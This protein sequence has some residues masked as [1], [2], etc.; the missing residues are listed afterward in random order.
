VLTRLAERIPDELRATL[1]PTVAALADADV[2][3]LVL[4]F[5]DS[6]AIRDDAAA[7]AC[8]LGALPPPRVEE[9]VASLLQGDHADRLNALELAEMV[10]LAGDDL[11][12]ALT[13]DPEPS[14]RAAAA[15]LLAARHARGEAGTL[16]IRMMHEASRDPGIMVPQA[17][18]HALRESTDSDAEEIRSRLRRHGSLRVRLAADANT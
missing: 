18:G 15:E 14:V 12:G 8:A 11:L 9:R 3:S 6:R 2:D 10:G 7:L 13:S 5:P 4:I 1:A 17:I 16:A